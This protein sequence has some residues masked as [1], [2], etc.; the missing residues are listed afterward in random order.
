MLLGEKSPRNRFLFVNNWYMF[1]TITQ[2]S[3]LKCLVAVTDRVSE[4]L[5]HRQNSILSWARFYEDAHGVCYVQEELA[6]DFC[7]LKPAVHTEAER[8][9]GLESVEFLPS[10]TLRLGCG[11]SGAQRDGMPSSSSLSVALFFNTTCPRWY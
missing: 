10:T 6:E 4:L 9:A 7:S 2:G 1:P 5:L 3:L 8:H 11:T